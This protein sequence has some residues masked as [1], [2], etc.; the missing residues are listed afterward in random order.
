MTVQNLLVVSHTHTSI[1]KIF[2]TYNLHAHIHIGQK[3]LGMLGPAH[4]GG[5][6]ADRI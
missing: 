3:N 6:V 4:S 2:V 1:P 5:G